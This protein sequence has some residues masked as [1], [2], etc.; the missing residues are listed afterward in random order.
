MG[1]LQWLDEEAKYGV[2]GVATRGREISARSAIQEEPC[3]NFHSRL[4]TICSSWNP[5]LIAVSTEVPER[6][7]ASTRAAC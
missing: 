6:L 3:A 2:K 1:H 4:K 5:C 7:L